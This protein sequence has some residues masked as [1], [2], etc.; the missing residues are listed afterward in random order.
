VVTG[1]ELGKIFSVIQHRFVQSR[2]PGG[3][4]RSIPSACSA[5]ARDL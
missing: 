1:I 3:S 4:S 5:S 2:G